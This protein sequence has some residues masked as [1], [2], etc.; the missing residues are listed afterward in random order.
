MYTKTFDRNG[1][2]VSFAEFI[3]ARQLQDLAKAR[4]M[5]GPK[6]RR[7]AQDDW[8][9]HGMAARE[10]LDAIADG[11]TRTAM[12]LMALRQMEGNFG[13]LALQFDQYQYRFVLPLYE[14]TSRVLL[15]TLARQDITIAWH[16]VGE[17]ATRKTRHRLPSEGV[18]PVLDLCQEELV[19][20]AELTARMLPTALASLT[21]REFVP[22]LIDGVGVKAVYV[23]IVY[24]QDHLDV[25]ADSFV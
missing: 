18:S 1:A 6:A 22:S 20:S 8:G 24:E 10:M 19:N 15:S 12:Q 13:I 5:S 3:S 16:P 2:T 11:R 9:L 17:G 14:P 7:F 23:A 25:I 21:S 4:G